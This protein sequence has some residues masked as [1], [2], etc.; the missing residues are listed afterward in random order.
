MKTGNSEWPNPDMRVEVETGCVERNA[1]S[2]FFN[3]DKSCIFETSTALP[4]SLMLQDQ[5]ISDAPTSDNM[6]AQ[7]IS[8]LLGLAAAGQLPSLQRA[9]DAGIAITRLNGRAGAITPDNDICPPEFPYPCYSAGSCCRTGNCCPREC[10]APDAK[11]CH[12][13]RCFR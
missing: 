12:D 4:Q 6:K 9:N 13:G 11:F 1:Y 2:I 7:F 8:T 3:L 10:C 5:S